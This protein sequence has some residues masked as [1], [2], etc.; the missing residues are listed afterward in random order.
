MRRRRQLLSTGVTVLSALAAVAVAAAWAA[1]VA[2]SPSIDYTTI[3]RS[4]E[5]AE[6]ATITTLA[7][8]PHRLWFGL[9]R[10]RLDRTGSLVTLD[11]YLPAGLTWGAGDE[12][13]KGFD[14]D[15]WWLPGLVRQPPVDTGF[16]RRSEVA[17]AVPF[18]PLL[19]AAAAR[20]AWRAWVRLR[21]RRHVGTA[22]RQCGYDLRASP[23]RCPECGAGAVT[24]PPPTASA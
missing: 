10:I 20:P 2:V 22:C 23:G 8:A 12:Y 14:D 21:H 17:L 24:P 16:G 7:T 13:R 19:L 3:D 9:T 4:A 5:P 18:W 6:V 15:R 11:A 1:S